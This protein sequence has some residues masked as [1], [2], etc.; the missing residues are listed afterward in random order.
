MGPRA[1]LFVLPIVGA[2]S[3]LSS[4]G[5]V[6]PASPPVLGG[7]KQMDA[8]STS[9]ERYA[10]MAVH[11]DPVIART[12]R[13]ALRALGQPGL[14]ALF[15]NEFFGEIASRATSL[16]AMADPAIIRWCEAVDAVSRQRDAAFSRLYWHTDLETAKA[17]AA[18][19]RRPILSLR[20]LGN[21]D[22]DRSCANSRYFR[23]VLYA[24]PT[25]AD[26]LRE[27]YVLHWESLRPVPHITIDMGDGRRI[28]RTITGNSVHYILDSDGRLVDVL[29]GLMNAGAFISIARQ[30][31]NETSGPVFNA[32]QRSPMIRAA[33]I[34]KEIPMLESMVERRL[35]GMTVS[36]TGGE[37]RMLREIINRSHPAG[38]D[39]QVIPSADR[40]LTIR[41]P[42]FSELGALSP[43]GTEAERVRRISI[44]DALHML[45]S[46]KPA[47]ISVPSRTLMWQKRYGADVNPDDP[48][49]NRVMMQ[50]F[51]EFNRTLALDTILNLHDIR[52]RALRRLAEAEPGAG[53]GA[54]TDL[55]T[56][57]EWLY[58]ELFLAPLDDPW[59]GL[60]PAN[61][62]VGLDREGLVADR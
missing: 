39:A 10:V 37:N 5:M 58:A 31:R 46:G 42:H 50:M 55:K 12:G 22:E 43:S 15:N 9:A 6:A 26:Y 19:S 7:Q 57:N 34:V 56:F 36:K 49:Q 17:R 38:N 23:T 28:E 30:A 25:V 45:T 27:N 60:A 41:F 21:L 4:F 54:T 35:H 8:A 59:M 61:A 18:E 16:S 33:N 40:L 44:E 14:D 48:E 29:P 53:A 62:Y 52:P 20:L 47:D 3:F 32:G 51:V 13:L 11:E 2:V 1:V 24:D